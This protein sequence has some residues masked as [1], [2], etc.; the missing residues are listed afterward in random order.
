[1]NRYLKL[2]HFEVQRFR[3]VLFG[4]M[5]LTLIIQSTALVW[6]TRSQIADLRD[7]KLHSL[8]AVAPE[9]RISFADMIMNTQRWFAT[10][11]LISIV[12]LGIYVFWIWYR[13]WF[14]RDT[15]AYRLLTLPTAR[16]NVYLAKITAILLFIFAMLSFQL[17]LLPIEKL[18]FN[19]TVPSGYREFSFLSEAISASRVFELLLPLDGSKFF[20]YYGLG[21]VAIFAVFTAILLERSYR[22]RGIV[23]ALFYIAACLVAFVVPML[24]LGLDRDDASLYPGEILAILTGIYIVILAVSIALGLRLISRK[25]TV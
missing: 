4:L 15:F 10:P 18:L 19:V 13:D 9:P 3:Y 20:I 2:V 14:G 21:I 22:W 11:I 8:M 6:M 16:R 1:M 5:A 25:I 24:T 12:V 23:Y 7:A 17:L